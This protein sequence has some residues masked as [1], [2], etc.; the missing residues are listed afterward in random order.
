[1][2]TEAIFKVLGHLKMSKMATC[3]NS[4]IFKQILFASSHF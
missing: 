1:M 2:D 4:K 3:R